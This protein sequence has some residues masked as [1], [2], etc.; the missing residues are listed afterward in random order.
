MALVLDMFVFLT[1]TAVSGFNED[2]TSMERWQ[3]TRFGA[4]HQFVLAS[5][6]KFEIICLKDLLDYI[7]N[8]TSTEKK[9][10]N[11]YT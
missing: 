6:K 9:Q 1:G 2:Q 8:P 4:T 5:H 10:Q 11:K 7:E 3:E